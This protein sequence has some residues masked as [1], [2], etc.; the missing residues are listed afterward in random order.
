MTASPNVDTPSTPLSPTGETQ[1]TPTD[2]SLENLIERA[3]EELA[4][5]LTVP[6]SDI[7]FLE[8][9]SVTWP[10]GSLGCP[11]EGMVYA[12]VLT[13]GYLI[14]LQSGDQEFE[15]HASRGTTI[16]YCENPTSPVPG[17]PGDI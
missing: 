3:K 2:V 5:R 17:T 9:E 6:V 13:P 10:D 15:Y 12:Q 8:A 1:M 14:R 4:Q 16:F 11:Q 7:V